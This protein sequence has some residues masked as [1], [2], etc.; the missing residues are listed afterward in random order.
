MR[1][2][3]DQDILY[4]RNNYGK[5][6]QYP[7]G[8]QYFHAHHLKFGQIDMARLCQFDN[9]ERGTELRGRQ[10]EQEKIDRMDALQAEMISNYADTRTPLLQWSLTRQAS[11]AGVN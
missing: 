8:E 4:R 10:F 9:W 1:V 5:F 3:I 6:F 11:G 7:A 2:Y